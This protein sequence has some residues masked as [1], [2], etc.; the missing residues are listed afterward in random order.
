MANIYEKNA[1]ERIIFYTFKKK[2]EH[3]IYFFHFERCRFYY[4]P[5]HFIRPNFHLIEMNIFIL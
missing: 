3:C 5:M 1:E 2:T 4:Q